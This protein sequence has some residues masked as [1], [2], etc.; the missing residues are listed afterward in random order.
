MFGRHPL[1]AAAETNARSYCAA[2][3]GGELSRTDG[4]DQQ[5]RKLLICRRQSVDEPGVQ[6]AHRHIA[7]RGTAGQLRLLTAVI[8]LKRSRLRERDVDHA[9][10][11]DRRDDSHRAWTRYAIARLRPN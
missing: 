2:V 1:K 8:E 3:A 9:A 4:A 7:D 5:P 10:V 6:H 11:A